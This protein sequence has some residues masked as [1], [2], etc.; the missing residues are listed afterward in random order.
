MKLA[1]S[2][3]LVAAVAPSVGC[4]NT[5]YAISANAAS[6]KLEEARELNAEQYA[7]YEYYLA[8]EHL[9]KAQS[10]AAEADYSDASNLAEAAEGYADKAIRL[11]RE[12]RR[13]AGR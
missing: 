9:E 12:A 13:G 6:S 11:S 3:T 8:K 4:G 2:L 10:E 1:V 7:P 5:L